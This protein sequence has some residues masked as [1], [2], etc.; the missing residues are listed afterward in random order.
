MACETC[1][2]DTF[3]KLTGSGKLAYRCDA[4]ASSHF[5][6]K[7]DRA[8]NKWRAAMKPYTYPTETETEEN[9]PMATKP[10]KPAKTTKPAAKRAPERQFL[11]SQPA[12][13]IKAPAGDAP[14]K[15]AAAGFVWGKL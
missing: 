9:K 4:C 15:P 6:E 13:D 7:G 12:D 10:T 3:V 8:Y 5:A 2:H 1:G 14:V 11:P